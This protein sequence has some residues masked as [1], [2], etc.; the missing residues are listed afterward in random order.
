MG[1]AVNAVSINRREPLDTDRI[2]AAGIELADA[3]GADALTMRRLAEHLGF[4]VMALYNHVA[5]KDE[6]LAL[7]VEAIAGSINLP[8]EDEEAMKAV[9]AHAIATRL[10]FVRHPWVPTL[11]QHYLPGPNRIDHMESLLRIFNDSGLPAATAHHG[12]HAINNHV[13]GYTLQEL[14]MEFGTADVDASTII[15]DFLST[16]SPDRHP[17]TIAHVHQHLDGDTGSSFE[18]V[19]DL[20]LAGLAGL[21]DEP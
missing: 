7:M 13:L 19:L 20:I 18:L 3:E 12:F 6:L 1:E 16:L 17:H 5:N 4:K 14:A 11:W 21:P 9:R 10:A 2:V 8:P 15:D